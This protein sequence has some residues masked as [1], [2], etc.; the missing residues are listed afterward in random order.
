M[1]SYKLAKELKDARFPYEEWNHNLCGY[2]DKCPKYH[3]PGLSQLIEACGDD[4]GGLMKQGSSWYAIDFY[5]LENKK[6]IGT[7][8]ST[9]K[10][11]VSRVWLTLNK[12]QKSKK[13]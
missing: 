5:N 2:G 9:P 6:E 3:Q 13:Q 10:E 1:I 7:I 12:K 8:G 4:F 11:A